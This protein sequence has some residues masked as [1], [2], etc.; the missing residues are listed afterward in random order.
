MAKKRKKKKKSYQ[1]YLYLFLFLVI[2]A[3]AG[4]FVFTHYNIK[5]VPKEESQA[6]Q[7]KELETKQSVDG[8]I[9]EAIKLLGIPQR[10]YSHRIKK[11]AVYFYIGINKNEMDLN[12][13]NL[14]ISGKVEENGGEIISGEEIGDGW[15]Q[16]LTFKD[17]QDEQLYKVVIYYAESAEYDEKKAQMAIV[18]D[19]FGYFAGK[20]LEDF[21]ELHPHLTYSILPGLSHSQEVMQKAAA[22]GHETIIHIP[23]EP[24]SYPKADPGKNAIFVQLSEKEIIKRVQNYIDELPLCKGANNHMGSLATADKDVMTVVLKVLK[25]ND[26]YFI[27]SRTTSSSVA[28]DTAQ[29]LLMP[30][31][32]NQMFLDSPDISDKTLNTKVRR[33]KKL[34]EQKDKFVIITHCTNREKYEYLKEFLRRIKKLDV[35]I[36]PASKLLHNKWAEIS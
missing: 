26:K 30:S 29:H 18:V 13:A 1:G 17:P 7:V 20:L 23:M 28:Y 19:D 14:V 15:K 8:V 3:L 31:L 25:D 32:E 24:I 5:L 34:V 27:D 16:I 4:Y 22:T 10:L 6:L 11:D 2:L 36:V 9:A 33:V 12:F 21:N 35:E